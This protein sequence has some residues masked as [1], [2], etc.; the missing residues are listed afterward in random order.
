MKK[1]NLNF[2]NIAKSSL[3]I[4]LLSIST[5]YAFCQNN[6]IKGT[7]ASGGKTSIDFERAINPSSSVMLGLNIFNRQ[8]KNHFESEGI[9]VSG[10]Y[11]LYLTQRNKTLSG[12]YLAPNYSIGKHQ[13]EYTKT[14]DSGLGLGLLFTSID[15]IADGELDNPLTLRSPE[16]ITGKANVVA[17][18]IGLKIGY[19]KRY[20]IINFDFGL[21]L[22]KNAIAGYSKGLQ[23]SDGSYKKFNADLVG[24]RP[25]IYLGIGFAF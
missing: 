19:Q 4:V 7:I 2:G 16:T 14:T 23:V 25:E 1:Q 11:R 8:D 3:I 24:N 5:Q 13:V 12:F 6:N 15:I 21:N 20:N 9:R 17:Q 22:R 10:E 18:T